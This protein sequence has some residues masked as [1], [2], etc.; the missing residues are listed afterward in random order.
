MPA[1]NGWCWNMPNLPPSDDVLDARLRLIVASYRRLTGRQLV[2]CSAA[3]DIAALRA[4]LW[5]APCAVV[6]HGTQAD[7]IFFY[8]NRRALQLFEMCFDEFTRL[9][10]RY[11]AEAVE[12]ATR[13]AL[14]E[15][16]TRLGF[17]DDYSGTRIAKSGKRF[18]IRNATVWNLLDEAGEYHGQAACFV[19]Q[20]GCFPAAC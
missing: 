19:V 18:Q 13:I 11:S 2:L 8:G 17:V 4:A 14:L 15:R 7:P 3:G 20:D 16:V 1:V 5:D 12:Q 6:A 10:S 9:P